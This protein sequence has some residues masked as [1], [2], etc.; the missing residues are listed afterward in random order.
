MRNE[1]YSRFLCSGYVLSARDIAIK[2]E[3][4]VFQSFSPH[5]GGY[6]NCETELASH[7]S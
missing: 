5:F 1:G 4:H 3:I 7:G 6:V 2:I